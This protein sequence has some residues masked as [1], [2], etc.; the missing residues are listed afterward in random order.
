MTEMMSWFRIVG[1]WKEEKRKLVV[2]APQESRRELV[3]LHTRSSSLPVWY[4][5]CVCETDRQTDRQRQRQRDR[6]TDRER[7]RMCVG[8]CV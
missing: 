7:E 2:A 4:G 8:V 5:V 3:S 6:Q 1:V